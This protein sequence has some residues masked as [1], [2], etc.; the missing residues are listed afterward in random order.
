MKFGDYHD[1][2]YFGGINSRKLVF[3]FQHFGDSPGDPAGGPWVNFFRNFSVPVK[4]FV[5]IGPVAGEAHRK[6]STAVV[7]PCWH[8]RP[9]EPEERDRQCS[10]IEQRMRPG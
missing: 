2:D 4:R 7:R 6:N 8:R 1:I 3:S 9:R 5:G 10:T